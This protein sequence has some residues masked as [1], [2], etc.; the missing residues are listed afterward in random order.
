[1]IIQNAANWLGR[2]DKTMYQIRGRHISREEFEKY[3]VGNEFL[4]WVEAVSDNPEAD[5]ATQAQEIG[6]TAVRDNWQGQI[7]NLSTQLRTKDEELINV[8]S[9]AA[10]KLAAAEDYAK[11]ANSTI[12]E[13]QLK[14][15][16]ALIQ[17]AIKPT[18]AAPEPTRQASPAPSG[19]WLYNTLAF[20]TKWKANK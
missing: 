16:Q 1:M 17:P 13:L 3:A 2:C 10:S 15:K 14:L 7:A 5:A 19:H 9:E 20:L 6:Q 12:T 8:R 11:S 18:A 4:R